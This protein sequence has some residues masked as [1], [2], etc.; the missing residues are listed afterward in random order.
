MTR[1]EAGASGSGALVLTI[2]QP[3]AAS[4]FWADPPKNIENRMWRTS[5]RGRLLIHAGSRADPGWER[6]PQAAVIAAIPEELRALRGV[7]L[8]EVTLVDCFRGS[9][10]PWAAGRDNRW[11]WLL[12]DPRPWDVPVPAVGRLRLW[13]F[14]GSLR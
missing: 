13:A 6:S 11:R 8:G 2:R 7:I 12:A 10:S 14:E 4:I 1:A 9:M 3:W 5:H